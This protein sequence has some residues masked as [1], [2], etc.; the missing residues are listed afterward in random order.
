MESWFWGD[1]ARYQRGKDIANEKEQAAKRGAEQR[2]KD[3]QAAMAQNDNGDKK[4][5][6]SAA[7]DAL[8]NASELKQ[9]DKQWL[10]RIPDD[11]GGLWRRKFLYQYKQQQQTRNNEDKTW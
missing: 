2:E 6:P 1:E 10:R 5:E 7:V 3:Q 4:G 9:A 11:P 8:D